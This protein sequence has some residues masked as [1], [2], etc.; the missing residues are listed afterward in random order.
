MFYC[1]SDNVWGR[2]KLDTFRGTVRHLDSHCR[3]DILHR[4]D[5]KS[6][7][8]RLTNV[9]W[10]RKRRH[11]FQMGKSSRLF[12]RH[13]QPVGLNIWYI[14]V[15]RCGVVTQQ[16]ATPGSDF[17]CVLGTHLL[18]FRTISVSFPYDLCAYYNHLINNNHRRMIYDASTTNIN[19]NSNPQHIVSLVSCP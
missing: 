6:T 1:Y 13:L 8:S 5:I 16:L 12:I 18:T 10:L 9:R 11:Y 15:V 7:E 14:S 17:L 4:I 3:R 2:K 19:V